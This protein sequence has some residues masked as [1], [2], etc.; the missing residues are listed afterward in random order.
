MQLLKMSLNGIKVNVD[1]YVH[2]YQYLSRFIIAN[3][4]FCSLWCTLTDELT[5]NTPYIY[6]NNTD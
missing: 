2:K 6:T 4:N 1:T 3:I 5:T